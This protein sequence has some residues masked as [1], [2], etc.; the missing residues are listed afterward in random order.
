MQVQIMP[1]LMDLYKLRGELNLG[2]ETT[3]TKIED[4]VLAGCSPDSP[5]VLALEDELRTLGRQAQQNNLEIQVMVADRRGDTPV[6]VS[7]VASES[8]AT[9]I[10]FDPN[11]NAYAAAHLLR[12][13]TGSKSFDIDLEQ[14]TVTLHHTTEGNYIWADAA[15]ELGW[16]APR[17]TTDYKNYL[18][19]RRGSWLRLIDGVGVSFP[20][21]AGFVSAYHQD[22]RTN[23]Y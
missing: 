13:A 23:E 22:D 20:V 4:A 8:T 16:E 15:Y 1:S 12:L 21:V 9:I 10:K 14:S 2:I 7:V 11:R 5:E 18:S 6:P 19:V 17:N 3:M